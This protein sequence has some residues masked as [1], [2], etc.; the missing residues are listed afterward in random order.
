[1]TSRSYVWLSSPGG[2]WSLASDWN[3]LT[4]HIDPSLTA[5]GAQDSVTVAG[6]S[7][8]SVQTVAGPGA[9]AL[10]MF[11]GNTQLSGAFAFGTL[12]LGAAGAG[13][14][15]EIL[16]GD[17][18]G[19]GTATI[20]TG[21]LLTG[22]GMVSVSGTLT[23][24]S[25]TAGGAATLYASGGGVVQ[26]AALFLG[27][28]SSAITVDPGSSV[29]VGTAGGAVDGALTID[30][31]ASLAGEGDANAYGDVVNNGLITAESGTLSLGAFSG[32]GSLV[33]DG[34]AALVLNG[35][36]G[37][38]Q[39]VD[40]AGA[41]ATLAIATEFDAPSG[42]IAGF[43]AGDAIDMLGSPIS[44]ATYTST[45]Q[46][47]GIL[48]LYYGSQIADTLHL[49]G[50]YAGDVFLP[51][52]DGAGG[53]DITVAPVVVSTGGPSPGTAS[54]DDYVWSAPSAGAW[55]VAGNWQDVTA[56]Q[57][58]ASIAPGVN[59]LVSITGGANSFLVVAGPGNAASLSVAGALALSG[60]MNIGTLAIGQGGSLSGGAV[61]AV[62]DL[63]P[64][65]VMQAQS[66]TVADGVIDVSG[67]GASLGVSGTLVLG[68]GPLGV[69]LPVA[70]LSASEG[71]AVTA[72]GLA[73][74]GG[75]GAFV[76]VDP[77]SSI[78]VGSG[79]ATLGAI[80]VSTGATLTG[81]GSVNPFAPVLDDG[82]IEASGAGG[83]LL[84]GAVSGSG[85]LVIAA[86]AALE[87]QSPTALPIDFAAASGSLV[88]VLDLS[89][90][91]A[92]PTG[93][94][95]GFQPGDVI[96]VLGD[97]ITSVGLAR[98]SGGGASTI[99][100][101]YGSTP[102]GRLALEGAFSHQIF[103][104]VPDGNG[105][106]DLLDVVQ[107][108]GGGGGGTGNTDT[109]AW[110]TPGTGNWDRAGNWNDLTTGEPATAPPGSEN[111]VIVAGPTGGSVQALG[112]PGTS[113]SLLFTGNTLLNGSF[114]TGTLSIGAGSVAA[115]TVDVGVSSQLSAA[116]A[117]VGAGG[118]VASGSGAEVAV[119][120][121]LAMGAE[122]AALLTALSG[123]DIELGGLVL[124]GASAV[125]VDATSTLEVGTLFGAAAGVMTI[126][127]GAQVSGAGSLDV[128]GSIV[129][130]GRVSAIGGTLVVGAFSGAGTLDIGT[131]ATL[132]LATA[133][134][135]ASACQIVFAGG[136][137]TLDLASSLT[138]SAAPLPAIIAG[139]APG[140]A[141]VSSIAPVTSLAFTQ[142]SSGLGT[143]ILTAGGGVPVDL[144]LAGN[145]GGDIFA[146]QPDGTG[147]EITVSS[148][149]G[150]GVSPG[151][152]SPDIYV[153]TGA[154]GAAWNDALNWEDS[155]ASQTP[156]AIA[157]GLHDLVTIA[158]A[159]GSNFTVI[160][161]PAD[162]ASLTLQGNVALGGQFAIG[163][164]DVASGLLALGAGS[165]LAAIS[166]SAAGGME[167]EAGS[168]SVVG[169]LALTGGSSNVLVASG[170]GTVS[171]AA[172]TLAS[173][174]AVLADATS[175]ID[176][177]TAG[178]AA[179]TVGDVTID[180]G[181]LA[182]GNGAL[183][184]LGSTIDDGMVIAAGGA[185][186][187]GDVSGDGTLLIAQGAD[188]SMLGTAGSGLIIDFAANGTLSAT[189]TPAA[190]IAGFGASDAILLPFPDATAASYAPNGAGSGL[191]TI[192]SQNEVLGVLT[193]LGMNADSAFSV[194][195]AA[196]G[197]TLLTTTTAQNGPGGGGSTVSGFS[198]TAG[199]QIWDT[200]Q[201][202]ASQPAAAQPALNAALAG[203]TTNT[204][205]SPDGSFFGAYPLQ[206]YANVAVASDP[207][208]L[209]AAW[210]PAGY[211]VLIAGGNNPV[212]L[213]DSGFG[214]SLLIGNEGADSL[215]GLGQNDT[216]I[217]GDG[218]NS[219]FW[220]VGTATMV[221]GGNDIFVGGDGSID[222]TTS[223]DGESAI[224][225]GAASNS[226]T[227]NGSDSVACLP[228]GQSGNDTVTAA[229]NAESG[230]L[231]V[232]P[233]VGQMLFYGGAGSAS[234]VGHAGYMVAYGGSGHSLVIGT[235]GYLEYIGGTGGALVVG[236]SG[237]M[238]IHG[239]AGALTVFGGTG[240]G[241]YAAEAGASYFVVGDGPSTVSASSGNEVWL[242]GSANVTTSVV[243]GGVFAWGAGSSGNNVFVAGTG[244]ATLVG[245]YGNDTFIAGTGNATLDGGS[246]DETFS[247]TSGEA[248]GSDLLQHFAVGRDDIAL[249]GYSESAATILAH[250]TVSGGNTT[251]ELNDGTHITLSGVTGLTASSFL[252]S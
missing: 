210:M 32:A 96:D 42:A 202:I 137:A 228:S 220:A 67:N 8:T 33:I 95:T 231:A 237:D 79:P 57:S 223:V 242:E 103:V 222:V 194:T 169:T 178:A 151:T 160:D 159:A 50:N 41:L 88:P 198:G 212:Y 225:L 29:E 196:G 176:I 235:D 43:A 200:D 143:L 141:I 31:G 86:G 59:D 114:A 173:G 189:V 74:G 26:T 153:W 226:V 147:S 187:V 181:G 206:G 100:L 230:C 110:A 3:D 131:E 247:F 22:G 203:L 191:L 116:T 127:L 4:D 217:G 64:G 104:A 65:A 183:D 136:G 184:V 243:G 91:L 204:W 19:A 68:G 62:L 211:R 190:A 164:V 36:T 168:L 163:G 182:S 77:D 171:A 213:V 90:E 66:A 83:T 219:V 133:D 132:E 150:T 138:G 229:G 44:A 13:G 6:P 175:L 20:D 39:S 170:G 139:F 221:G 129:E 46:T 45:G 152:T 56:G 1:M 111:T 192:T 214:D 16:G 118:I 23:L 99:T 55:N 24:G 7:G 215:T 27:A 201:F 167:V 52:A 145:F 78:L 30:A 245:G 92:L 9:A 25:A 51:S 93:T 48:T 241:N 37:G 126:D 53:T 161:G 58:P 236:M 72:E 186:S 14:L 180:A 144:L 252:T 125:T 248:G 117:A 89:S 135:L 199:S 123:A 142:G 174:S 158:G 233:D 156:A 250:D 209:S 54:P 238:Y 80:T 97:Q 157:P 128:A 105:G 244:P 177:G 130:N 76:T 69:G 224:W 154:A 179:G 60:A 146:L 232:G 240:H 101:Y 165:G 94:L 218:A 2:T 70:S 47:T 63:V 197:G 71:A 11:S 87:L 251:L 35:Q 28:A 115:G 98:N 239:G 172:L 148:T 166:A 120:G 10:A 208:A 121:T 49:I 193:L 18:L 61:P 207:A 155:S 216:L 75:Y 40:F 81:N 149:S 195:G 188:L 107:A 134:P 85:S 34:G 234:I 15:L 122:G 108:G 162:A 227:L 112:G 185:L 82:V 21:S 73:M 119:S 246:G 113:T 102:V 84:L 124:Q 106:T 17:A 12:V 249:H 38:G 5:P 140:D 109:L 205:T